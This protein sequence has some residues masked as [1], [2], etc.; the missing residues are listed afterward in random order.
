MTLV[1]QSQGRRTGLSRSIN[2]PSLLQSL[3]TPRPELQSVLGSRTTTNS[4][5]AIKMESFDEQNALD[6]GNL[7]RLPDS[8]SDDEEDRSADIAKTSF[9]ARM[10]MPTEPVSKSKE[11]AATTRGSRKSAIYATSRTRGKRGKKESMSSSPP[12]S[13]KRKSSEDAPVI[14]AGMADKLGFTKTSQNKRL[15]K[16]SRASKA[17]SEK[18]KSP[19]KSSQALIGAWERINLLLTY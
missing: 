19:F 2:V 3:K 10:Q 5:S 7:T 11:K 6:K 9:V 18:T 15:K 1:P 8:S 13:P 4:K 16:F 17:S 12:C 14:G